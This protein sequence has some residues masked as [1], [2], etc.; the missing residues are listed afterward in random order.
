MT[1]FE[2]FER[3]LHEQRSYRFRGE[4]AAWHAKQ[5]RRWEAIDQWTVAG[6]PDGAD[7]DFTVTGSHVLDSGNPIGVAG[8][9][10]RF[11]ITLPQD[12]DDFYRKWDGGLL[13]FR[14]YYPILSV[15][16]IIQVTLWHRD[17]GNEGDYPFHLIRFCDLGN[18][19]YLAFR[20]S[21]KQEWEVIYK[22]YEYPDSEV[23][24]N[25]HE[26]PGAFL[27]SDFRHWLQRM[28]DTDGWP[29]GGQW[30]RR[31]NEPPPAERVD[32]KI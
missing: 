31:D 5:L 6:K 12:V 9:N 1:D 2:F 14:Q 4:Q 10:E 15:Q 23:I 22:A 21:E 13:L 18:S 8:L 20:F 26:H 3:T 30:I 29:L 19:D 28:I 11:N 32:K 17:I 7:A 24:L 27:D 25:W 16:Q